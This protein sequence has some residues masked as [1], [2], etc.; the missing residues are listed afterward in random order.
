MPEPAALSV[1]DLRR[2]LK[3]PCGS[4]SRPRD[5]PVMTRRFHG[6]AAILLRHCEGVVSAPGV[7][8]GTY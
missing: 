1:E 8:P 4:L 2:M 3:T 6:L 7:E 5:A